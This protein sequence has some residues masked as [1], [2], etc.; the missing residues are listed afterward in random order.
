MLL[1]FFLGF[2]YI[3]INLSKKFMKEEVLRCP[4]CIFIL[5][6]SIMVK[7]FLIEIVNMKF[8]L[9]HMFKLQIELLRWLNIL[10][11]FQLKFKY[12]FSWKISLCLNSLHSYPQISVPCQICWVLIF[13]LQFLIYCSFPPRFLLLM[14][15]VY[16]LE[17]N[18]C[19]SPYASEHAHFMILKTE[20]TDFQR[21]YL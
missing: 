21:R 5:Q 1:L 17:K 15:F 11:S 2:W 18:P 12:S 4:F 13:Y 6:Y 10:V 20:S 19:S 14:S 16:V 3:L 9:S 7:H 8:Y